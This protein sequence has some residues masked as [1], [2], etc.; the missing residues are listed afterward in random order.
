L[1]ALPPRRLVP[2]RRRDQA[3]PHALRITN[4]VLAALVALSVVMLFM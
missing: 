1:I 2:V 3:L 4:L